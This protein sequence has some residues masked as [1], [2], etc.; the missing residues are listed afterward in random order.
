MYKRQILWCGILSDKA[1]WTTVPTGSYAVLCIVASLQMDSC[2]RV[3]FDLI[4]VIWLLLG[5]E[6]ASLN[7]SIT[8][9]GL[10]NGVASKFHLAL[11]Y[12]C[13]VRRLGAT[14][15]YNLHTKRLRVDIKGADTQSSSESSRREPE[16]GF[17]SKLKTPVENALELSLIHI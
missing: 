2:R 15:P 17:A 7:W 8:P 3:K 11:D 14:L 10:T 6:K 16:G 1:E 4:Y 13:W 12:I 9:P 5:G